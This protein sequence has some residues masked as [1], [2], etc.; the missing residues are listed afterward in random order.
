MKKK[1]NYK[2]AILNRATRYGKPIIDI[3]EKPKIKYYASLPQR[4]HLIFI[5]GA[6]RTGSTILYQLLTQYLDVI[7]MDNLCH[8]LYRNPFFGCYLSNLFFKNKPHDSFKSNHG[9]TYGLHSPSEFWNFWYRWLPKDHHFIDKEE[10]NRDSI[11]EIKNIIFS[12]INK[13]GKPV[14]FKNMH[15]GQRMRLIYGI[16]PNTKFIFLKREP[17][18]IAQSLIIAKRKFGLNENDWWSTKPKNY[19]V[20]SKLNGCKMVVEQVFNIEK[21]IIEDSKFFKK[22]NFIK[23]HYEDLCCNTIETI[24]RIQSFLQTG[25]REGAKFRD[26]NINISNKLKLKKN[27]LKKIDAEIKK[28]DWV[29]YNY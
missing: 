16:S 17:L 12:L 10:I 13:Y 2:L 25:Y 29:N 18:Y 15:H 5:I 3:W 20:L 22:D 11:I 7:Y 27:I 19:K 6:P 23:I 28:H 14:L 9:K 8:M 1:R 21:Q 24:N 26:V 4:H